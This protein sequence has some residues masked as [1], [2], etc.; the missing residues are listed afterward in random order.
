MPFVRRFLA[1]L[2]LTEQVALVDPSGQLS[3][4]GYQRVRNAV[5]AKAYGDS[6]VLLRM[7]ESLD[8][9]TRNLTRALMRVAP[10]VAQVRASIAEG[11]LFDADITPDLVSA[12][13]GMSRIKEKGIPTKEALAQTDMFGGNLTPEARELVAFLS[14]NIRSPRRIA[15]FIQA[16][17]DALEA[18]GSPAQGSLLGDTAAPSKAD[19]IT[20]AR[21]KQ[22]AELAAKDTIRRKPGENI[23]TA[24]ES[25]RRPEDTSRN[26][27]GAE[28]YVAEAGRDRGP[29]AEVEE[30][31]DASTLRIDQG[32]PDQERGASEGSKTAGRKDLQREPQAGG[33]EAQQVQRGRDRKKRD[34]GV[35]KRAA[36]PRRMGN[37]GGDQIATIQTRFSRAPSTIE[38]YESR[39]DALWNGAPLKYHGVRVLDRSDVLDLL[40]FGGQ[41][42]F[43]QESKIVK[44]KAEH[45]LTSEHWKKVP[46]WLENPA[47]VLDSDTVAG[48]LV[49]LAPEQL[50]GAPIVMV[51]E[52]SADKDGTKVN[53]L[54]NVYDKDSGR[55]PLRRWINEGLLRYYDKRT[56]PAILA[57]SGLQLS[58]LAQARGRSG[59]ILRDDDLV[60]YRKQSSA[61]MSRAPSQGG[62]GVP[63]LGRGAGRGMALRDLQAVVDRVSKGFQNLPRVH[64]LES[65][66]ALSTKDPSQK[67][68][69]DYIRQAGAWDDVEGATHDGEIY[70]FA[71]GLSDEA[72]VIV[73]SGV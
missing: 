24:E 62:Y 44:G 42:V 56:S 68:L 40:G 22:D 65:P 41:P 21:R 28:G 71:S 36:K 31:K 19:L 5:L 33:T 39:I 47:M 60:K 63:L 66:D 4:A 73:K 2:P 38:T 17:L 48:R 25:Q 15:D 10:R 34:Q 30:R 46:Q 29:A 9:N 37:D 50:N 13:E 67:V 7:V 51:V 45:N 61:K 55:M 8:D 72:R 52:P 35:E 26:Q 16:Y 59:K 6:P 14:D 18:Y 57:R 20:A 70:L 12:V 54:V 58:S 3:Q 69:R 53:L 49:F 1:K 64:V 23:R 27:V 11:A 43:L 32:Q